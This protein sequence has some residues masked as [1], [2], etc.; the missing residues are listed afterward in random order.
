MTKRLKEEIKDIKLE[1]K[2]TKAQWKD[3]NRGDAINFAVERY[4]EKRIEELEVKLNKLMK[5]YKKE[6]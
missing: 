1:I 3:L 2:N 4:L 6:E 5:R